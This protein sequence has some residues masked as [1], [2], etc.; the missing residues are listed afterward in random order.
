MGPEVSRVEFEQQKR[1]NF[2]Q[3]QKINEQSNQISELKKSNEN[4]QNNY[5]NFEKIFQNTNQEAL[6][7]QRKFN[8]ELLRNI[9]NQKSKDEEYK[10]KKP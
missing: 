10:Q 3:Q 5:K 2:Y 9:E 8:A 4:L 7:E 1:T 6:N